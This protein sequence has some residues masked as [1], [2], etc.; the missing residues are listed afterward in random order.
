MSNS[1]VRARRRR[2]SRSRVSLAISAAA[3]LG[4]G[5]LLLSPGPRPASR[6]DRFIRLG[7]AYPPELGRVYAAAWREGARRLD[8]GEP[9]AS[10]IRAVHQAWEAGRIR[11]FDRVVTPEFAAIVPENP[12]G[13][14]AG[15]GDADRKA[16]AWAWREFAAGLED[17]ER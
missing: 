17:A 7:R 3:L 5:I 1:L 12:S 11:L 13:T 8:D 2:P 10:A 6:D 9:I 16:L 15:E 14:L 4:L